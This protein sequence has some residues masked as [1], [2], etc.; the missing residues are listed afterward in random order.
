MS[1]RDYLEK[2]YYGVLGVAKTASADEIKKAYRK[3]ARKLH[4]DANAGDPR[5]RTGSRRS[6]RPTTCCPT[7]PSAGSTTRCASTAV[8]FGGGRFGAP[9]GRVRPGGSRGVNLGDLFGDAGLGDMLGGL[10]GGRARGA[11]VARKGDD[12]SGA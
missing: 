11:A 12:L 6:P 4:P 10:F 7:T 1:A 9:A 5:P 8:R 2:D 3:L